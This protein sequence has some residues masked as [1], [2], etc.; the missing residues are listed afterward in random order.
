MAFVLRT[1]G[2]EPV[3]RAP[4]G[5]P[6]H[7]DAE[8]VR[9]LET[10]YSCGGAQHASSGTRGVPCLGTADRIGAVKAKKLVRIES[11]L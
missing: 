11:D 9:T 6:E 2:A 5:T 8:L 1:P 7:V 3:P 10:R 4:P